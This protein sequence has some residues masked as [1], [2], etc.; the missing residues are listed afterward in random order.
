E[1][2]WARDYARGEVHDGE[3]TAGFGVVGAHALG[4]NAGSCGIVLIG[5]FTK[6]RPTHA[7]LAA[8]VHLIAWKAA[9]HRVDPL[10]NEEYIS[11]YGLHRVFP[12]IAGHRQ[13]GQTACPGGYLF[14]QLPWVRQQVALKTGRFPAKTIDMSKALRWTDGSSPLAG[15]LART[16]SPVAAFTAAGSTSSSSSGSRGSV[17]SANPTGAKLTGYRLLTND[18][19]V[20]TLGDASRFGSPRDKGLD[21]G[22]AI[23]GVPGRSW[24]L[25]SDP[26]GRVIG[27][28]GAAGAS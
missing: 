24:Y 27:F 26:A 2:R 1:A 17:T 23:A 19:R 13:T 12:N 18:G 5:D 28:G 4:V 20:I 6:G 25:T 9:R 7:A 3:D 21:A 10:R 16:S 11:I 22:R 14:N 15:A 8:L